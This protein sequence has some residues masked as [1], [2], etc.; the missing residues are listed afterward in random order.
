MLSLYL[1]LQRGDP[2]DLGG[3]GDTSIKASRFVE[4]R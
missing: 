3:A 4:V 2:P 1:G